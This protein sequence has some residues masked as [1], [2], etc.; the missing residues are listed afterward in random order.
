[1][2]RALWGF[3]LAVLGVGNQWDPNGNPIANVGSH[4]D[5]NG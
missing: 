4:W 5:P 1:M 2:V 3:V